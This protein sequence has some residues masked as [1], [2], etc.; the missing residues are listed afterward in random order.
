MKRKYS[1]NVFFFVIVVVVVV[2]EVAPVGPVGP[3]VL[4]ATRET[5]TAGTIVAMT[6]EA[7]IA[8]T[9]GTT[10][11]PTGDISILCTKPTDCRWESDLTPKSL[12][13]L[14]K[15]TKCF[16]EGDLRHHTTGGRIGLG[17]GRGLILPPV[18]PFHKL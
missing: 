5:M 1:C 8:M 11:D 4:G 6:E 9:T 18:S 17:P 13:V 7:T 10:T 2:V 14:T 15:M 3:V 16:S 12:Y